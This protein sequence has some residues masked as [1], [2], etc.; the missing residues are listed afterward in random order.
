MNELT[1][2]PIDVRFEGLS[3]PVDSRFAGMTF[4]AYRHFLDFE[5][6]RRHPQ[7]P[8]TPLVMPVALGAFVTGEPVALAL[9]EIRE[10]QT[11]NAEM[12][13]LF[14]VPAYRRRG[15]GTALL[16]SMGAF[17]SRMGVEKAM[18]VYMTGQPG[19]EAVERVLEKAGWSKPEIRQ[20]TLRCTLE[21]ARRL[22][23]YGKYALEEGYSVF[24][25]K[26][27]TE[28]DREALKES[29]RVTGWIKPDLEPWK[30]DAEGFEPVS[31]LGI[32]LHG[33]LVGWIINHALDERVVRFTCS[34]IRRDLGRRG[35]IVPV[36]T[37]SIRRLSEST[38]FVEATFTVPIRHRG[39]SNFVLRRSAPF[40]SFS[41]LGETR[42]TTKILTR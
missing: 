17:L 8:N 30:H 27:L 19:Q 36:Y 31:S 21:E 37:E 9:A 5:P 32:R 28:T 1:R 14:V 33:E 22:D 34:F 25:W 42:G 41:F 4:P 20:L 16:N 3:A 7:A 13:S 18:G 26:D 24:P 23:W 11:S 15:L 38:G 2:P 35:K 39:M 10:G 29:Q 6:V 40:L 12:L